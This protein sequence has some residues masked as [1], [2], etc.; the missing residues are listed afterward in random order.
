M[1]EVL[2]VENN[3]VT[4]RAL[5]ERLQAAG[6]SVIGAHDGKEAFDLIAA[7]PWRPR[8]I[9]FDLSTPVV[10]GWDFW[11]HQR[12]GP[13]LARIPII[14]ISAKVAD[15]SGDTRDLLTT[16]VGIDALLALIRQYC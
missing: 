9:L 15:V 10:E 2:V 5:I 8:L 12:N 6:H 11:E 3:G 1:N 13:E 14:S 16:P 4:L 7:A